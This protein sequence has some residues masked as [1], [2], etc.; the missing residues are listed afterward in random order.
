MVEVNVRLNSGGYD[1]F[2]QFTK[3]VKKTDGAVC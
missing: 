2:K 1:S 3:G